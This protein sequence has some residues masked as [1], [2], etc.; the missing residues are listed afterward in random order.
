L[1]TLSATRGTLL[2][3]DARSPSTHQ[4]K[5]AHSWFFYLIS[6]SQSS[7]YCFRQKGTVGPRVLPPTVC[8]AV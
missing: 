3:A 5:H 1:G 2:A 7:S 8:H 4:G 6:N